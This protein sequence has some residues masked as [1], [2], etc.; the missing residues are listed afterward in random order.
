MLAVIVKTSAKY[1][2]SGFSVFSPNLK[3]GVG[4][5]GVRI[6]STFSKTFSK[7][8]P[9]GLIKNELFQ[10]QTIGQVLPRCNQSDNTCGPIQNEKCAS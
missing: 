6:K 1:I 8:S 7:S 4:V 9:Y 5:V 2:S 3:A 10:T